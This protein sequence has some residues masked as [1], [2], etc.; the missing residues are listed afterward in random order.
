MAIF[1]DTRE[2]SRQERY[3]GM[4]KVTGWKKAALAMMGYKDT[5]EKNWFGKTGIANSPSTR[6]LSKQLSKGTDTQK[7]FKETDDEWAAA[8]LAKLKFAAEVAAVVAGGAAAGSA[9]AATGAKVTAGTK[10]GTKIPSGATPPINPTSQSGN[11]D[12]ASSTA[13]QNL[14]KEVSKQKTQGAIE[15]SNANVNKLLEKTDA[16]LVEGLGETENPDGTLNME[17]YKKRG[18]D[19]DKLSDEEK[20]LLKKVEKQK[21]KAKRE[22]ALGKAAD[23]LDNVPVIGSGL[24]MVA[25]N[26]AATLAAEQEA[27]KYLKKTAK[28]T[29]FNLL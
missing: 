18:I 1:D 23:L 9:G 12:I 20:E 17:E 24:D 5:G 26:R 6:F 19:W 7:V 27:E 8:E 22:E 4:D 13:G 10:M 15:S 16:E 28:D 29:Q 3:V 11:F 25:K 21:K 14:T 2:L